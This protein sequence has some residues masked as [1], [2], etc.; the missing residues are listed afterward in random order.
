VRRKAALAA[1]HALISSAR[2][3][4]R[5]LCRPGFVMYIPAVVVDQ[6]GSNWVL[7]DYGSNG[8]QNCP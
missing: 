2:A 7:V 1:R 6:P 4:T 3:L 5:T 8:I